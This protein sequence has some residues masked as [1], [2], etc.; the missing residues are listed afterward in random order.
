[1]PV[2]HRFPHGFRVAVFV[3]CLERAYFPLP[4]PKVFGDIVGH[5][6]MGMYE[7][8]SRTD[9]IRRLEEFEAAAASPADAVGATAMPDDAGQRLRA[10]LETAVEGIITINEHGLIESMNPAAERMFGYPLQEVAGENVN[11]LMPSPYREEHD[12]YLANYRHTGQRK[13]IGIG[14]TVQGRKRDGTVFPLD[15]AVSEVR[16][17]G[18]RLFT[19]FV[20]DASERVAAQEQLAGLARTLAERNKELETIVYVASHDLRSP[21]VNIQGFSKELAV[22]C[23]RLRAKLLDPAADRET[24]QLLQ[25]EI[26]EA[27][28][29]IHA[30][31]VKIDGLLSG[32]L[33]YS[34]LGRAALNPQ[35]LNMDGMLQQILRSIEFQVQQSGAVVE[36]G[37]LPECVGDAV[38]VNQ[39][40]SNLLDNALKYLDPRRPGRI[41]VAGRVE[42]AQA[43][44]AVRDNGLGIAPAHQAKV[45]EIFHRLTPGKGQG[46]GLGLTIAQRILERQKGRIWLESVPGGGSTFYVSL[47][48]CQHPNMAR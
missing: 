16:L 12:T 22:A 30:G 47:P 33:R 44:Y 2:D 4:N 9:L 41:S 31:V 43:I 17:P 46:E 15:L 20:R 48:A 34:R 42:Q 11:V 19:G 37:A 40:F 39:V 5:H 18:R 3:L 32:F 14:R 28:E 35:P 25:E 45:F 24:H 7:H 38:Q 36:V 27:L 8:W 13:I 23:E 29:Y 1:M 26:P 21:L 10:I 6:P